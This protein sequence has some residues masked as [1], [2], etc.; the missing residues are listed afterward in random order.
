MGPALQA[1]VQPLEAQPSTAETVAETIDGGI[2]IRRHQDQ[3]G[4][5]FKGQHSCFGGAVPCADRFHHKG[6]GYHQPVEPH[7]A[8]QQIGEHGFGEGGGLLRIQ[9]RQHQM[10]RHHALHTG[11]NGGLKGRKFDL[12]QPFAAVGQHRQVQMGVAA[13]VAVAGKV[14]GASEHPRLLEPPLER[15]RQGT[16][17]LGI[18]A[19]GPHIDHRVGGVVVDVAHRPQHP[20][21]ATA[22]GLFAGAAAIA[23]TQIQ[24]QLGLP[25]VESPEGQ[26]RHQPAGPF[27]ALA[28]ALFNVRADQQ[29]LLTPAL[30]LLGALL[31]LNSAAP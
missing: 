30:Q 6:I 1:L 2:R 29:P 20:V 8:P 24:G 21:Q 22:A 27:E 11:G 19:P 16:G 4:P 28:N 31:Q 3:V 18:L 26:G 14:L 9:F 25:L 15:H 12:L 5:G 17:S 7:L 13:G 23:L 10:G